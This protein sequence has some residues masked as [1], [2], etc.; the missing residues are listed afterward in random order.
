MRT[1]SELRRLWAPPCDR[2]TTVL[3]LHSNARV[4]VASATVDAFRALDAVMQAHDYAPRAA[5]TGGYNCRRITGGTSYSLHAY[6]VA[7][8]I[9]WNTNPYRAD[10]R[11]VTDMPAGMV[12][13]IKALRTSAGKPVFRWGGD[14]TRVKDA[15]HFEVVASPRELDAG[16]DW[17][18]ISLREPDPSAPATWPV[19]ERGA[20]GP[21]VRTLQELLTSADCPC[22]PIDGIFGPGTHQAVLR[23][24][25][26]RSLDV[27][28]VV[29]DD[30]QRGQ[31][32]PAVRVLG[33]DAEARKRAKEPTE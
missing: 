4:R 16:I 25:E 24:Q 29:A 2:A 22:D 15:M 11:L 17:S 31:R 30:H 21:T 6:G 12:R 13:D 14:Y 32:E 7:V 1:T 28:G 18:G 10:G 9:N 8:D 20:R 19:R 26:T 23:Y 3:L 33:E 27:D 5:D